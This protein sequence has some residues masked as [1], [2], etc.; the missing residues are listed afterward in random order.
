MDRGI[1]AMKHELTFL[2]KQQVELA[3][4]HGLEDEQIRQLADYHYN[5]RQMEQ[6]RQQ[7]ARK[8]RAQEGE[9]MEQIAKQREAEDPSLLPT[10]PVQLPVI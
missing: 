10:A 1:T 2:Q 6:L 4:L 9:V 3:R 8:R 5:Y 7:L